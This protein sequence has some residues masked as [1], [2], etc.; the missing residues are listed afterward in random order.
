MDLH[1][2]SCLQKV[3]EVQTLGIISSVTID[4]VMKVVYSMKRFGSP[5]L[6]GVPASFYQAYWDS[7]GT[8]ITNLVN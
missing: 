4:E 1:E 6:H 5:R 8:P 2:P 7:A 3:E